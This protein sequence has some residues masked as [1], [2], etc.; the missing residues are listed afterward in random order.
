MIEKKEEEKPFGIINSHNLS[1][2]NKKQKFHCVFQLF[3]EKNC[4]FME[5]NLVFCSSVC[6]SS[7]TLVAIRYY[8]GCV[9]IFGT[10]KVWFDLLFGRLEISMHSTTSY[11]RGP[12]V[13][14]PQ[15]PIFLI[16]CCFCVE[17]FLSWYFV[18]F[19]LRQTKKSYFVI[20]SKYIETEF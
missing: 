20:H 9:E 16:S 19:I 14:P 18:V 4:I 10:L 3:I 5:N 13:G 11:F 1:K 17:L 7:L 15:I 6:F 2:I 8:E 12:F